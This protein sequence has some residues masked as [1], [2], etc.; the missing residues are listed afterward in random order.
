MEPAQ[1]LK[2]SS[3]LSVLTPIETLR[4]LASQTEKVN[5]GELREGARVTLY[6]NGG[7]LSGYVGGIREDAEASYILLIEHDDAVRGQGMNI[8]YLPLWAVVAVKV[9]EADQ[10]LNLLSGGKIETKHST[11][12]IV[13]LRKKIADETVKLR[14]VM[15]VDIKLEVSWE[16]LSQDDLTL[17]GLYELIDKFMSVV[18]EQISDEFKRIAFKM[19]VTS[20]RFQNS[21][22]IE[23][24][25]DEQ[26][27]I[28]RA[29]LK[30]R[31]AGRFTQEEYV[32]ALNTV[33]ELTEEDDE[34]EQ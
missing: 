16:T 26:I 24:S 1:K 14:A 27:L 33:L 8:V 18:H 34:E 15:Q 7:V 20:I 17:I 31:E 11:P 6:M 3:V 12:G 30:K 29:D 19:L 9:H 22:D 28:I 10:F 5:R 4:L 23:L 2:T 32:G 13:G 25:L 21:T